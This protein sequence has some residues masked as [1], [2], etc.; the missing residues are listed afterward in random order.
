MT[1]IICFHYRLHDMVMAIIMNKQMTNYFVAALLPAL[2][3]ASKLL[4]TPSD[5]L[6]TGLMPLKCLLKQFGLWSVERMYMGVRL[7]PKAG[8]MS[9]A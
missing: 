3:R 9:N 7:P 6:F 5:L 2:L 1:C 4:L 8:H